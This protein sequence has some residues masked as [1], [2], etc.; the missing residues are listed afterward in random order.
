V[1]KIQKAVADFERK[2]GALDKKVSDALIASIGPDDTPAVIA[3]KISKA[4]VGLKRATIDLLTQSL[5]VSIGIGANNAITGAARIKSVKAWLLENAYSAAG[6]PIKTTLNS[7]VDILA[8]K[9]EIT[10]SLTANQSWRKAAQDLSDKK[11]LVAD[12]AKDVQSIIDKA[13]GVY[14]LT[15]DREAYQEYKKAVAVVQ[16]RINRLTDQD[17][18]KLRRA[19][20]DILDIT[21]KSSVKQVD[22]A[23]KYAS[24]FKQRYNAERI[25]RTEMARA[26]GDAAFSDAIYNDLAIGVQFTLSSG[27]DVFDICDVHCG[28]DL[29]GMG[30]GIYPKE[31]A[32]AYPFHVQCHCQISKVYKREAPAN[33][34][35]DYD[36][37]QA[38]K[39]IAGLTDRQKQELLGVKGV[40]AFE[41]NPKS[42]EKNLRNW[43]GQEKKT[44]TIPKDMLYGK[45]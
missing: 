10:R 19:Y 43:N 44:A 45:E 29:Y 8:V 6:V 41:K 3:R 37:K 32:P 38:Q 35:K 40:E 9:R 1:N 34:P 14:G 21:N 12:V 23:I 39:Y 2:N 42:W 15:N 33:G 24:Y 13:R 7:S 28:A 25:A 5:V 31:Q 26:Y 11:I 30:E 20:Q 16:Q 17:T 4:T 36:K 27:H 22:S 18:S